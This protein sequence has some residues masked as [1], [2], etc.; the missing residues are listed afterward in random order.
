MSAAFGYDA[1]TR[2]R[3][4]SRYVTPRMGREMETKNRAP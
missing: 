3:V 4:E 1:T 2:V